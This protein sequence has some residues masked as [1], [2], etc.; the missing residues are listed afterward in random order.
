MRS[1]HSFFEQSPA[2]AD[3]NRTLWVNLFNLYVL[4][5]IA[6]TCG[7]CFRYIYARFLNKQKA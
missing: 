3:D 1:R 7:A 6:G 4:I 5:E 2:Y